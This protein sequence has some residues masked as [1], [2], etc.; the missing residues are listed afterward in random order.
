ML[1]ISGCI[2]ATAGIFFDYLLKFFEYPIYPLY[3]YAAGMMEKE[4]GKLEWN[5]S[6]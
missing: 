3:V 5:R 6:M 2:T 4:W 1:P